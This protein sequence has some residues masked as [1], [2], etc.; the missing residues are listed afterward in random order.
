MT[1][2][3]HACC[4]MA[5]ACVQ[6]VSYTGA[7]W[8]HLCFQPRAGGVVQRLRRRMGNIPIM[9]RSKRCYL[10]NLSRCSAMAPSPAVLCDCLLV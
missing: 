6:S 5:H 10:R 1:A 8:M 7:L 3:M 2:C 4:D 9:L